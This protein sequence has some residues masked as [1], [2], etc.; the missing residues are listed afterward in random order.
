M[1]VSAFWHGFYPCY[2]ANFFHMGISDHLAK[3]GFK[4]YNTTLKPYQEMKGFYIVE[5]IA[6]YFPFLSP[7]NFTQ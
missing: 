5:I 4:L 7:N 6:L 1:Q 3:Q 2:Y